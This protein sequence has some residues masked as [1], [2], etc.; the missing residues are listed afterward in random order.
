MKFY[1]TRPNAIF[2]HETLPA[3]CIPKVVRMEIGKV[4]YEN[5]Y[6]SPRPPP[7]ISLKHDCKRELCSED[8]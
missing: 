3:Y 4:I 5:V 8:A 6:M 1:Q 2:L 7:K